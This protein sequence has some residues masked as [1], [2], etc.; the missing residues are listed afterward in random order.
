MK[1]TTDQTQKKYL[2]I[3]EGKLNK[4]DILTQYEIKDSLRHAENIYKTFINLHDALKVKFLNLYFEY[5]F[6]IEK[7]DDLYYI[8]IILLWS[9]K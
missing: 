6:L 9:N 1:E 7:Y 5:M 4:S 3:V 2:R 8:L